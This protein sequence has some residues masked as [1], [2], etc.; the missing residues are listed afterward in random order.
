[1]LRGLEASPYAA[2]T[3]EVSSTDPYGAWIDCI[4]PG[5]QG[6]LCSVVISEPYKPSEG[7]AVQY[8]AINQTTPYSILEDWQESVASNCNATDLGTWDVMYCT[9]ITET[10]PFIYTQG[11][12]SY[13]TIV[14]T[15]VCED[16]SSLY[17]L[18]G[19]STT[20][21][22]ESNQEAIK[23]TKALYPDVPAPADKALSVGEIAGI[24]AGGIAG[25]A[26]LAF[27]AMW[28]K[29]RHVR[30]KGEQV[31]VGPDASYVP[32]PEA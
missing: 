9:N 28:C 7:E 29:R 19:A 2:K 17:P 20:C 18:P 8:F 16:F 5:N 14:R 31:V 13:Q 26:A 25:L 27:G 10:G 4:Q 6:A 22:W 11:N 21:F 12:Q 32:V 1:M 15:G 3:L 30:A 24:A 23:V